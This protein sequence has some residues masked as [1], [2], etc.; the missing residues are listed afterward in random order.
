MNQTFFALRNLKKSLD[1]KVMLEDVNLSV[2]K[3]EFWSVVG[4]SG[5]GKSTLFE[6]IGGICFPDAGSIH[7]DGVDVTRMQPAKRPVNML[8][9]SYALFP[10]MSVWEN[11]AY[12]LKCEGKS[13][14]YIEGKVQ[15]MLNTLELWELVD[16]YPSQLSGG[17]KQ[18]VA[19]G[20]CL[21]KNPKLVLLD[22]PFSACD[23]NIRVKIQREIWDYHKMMNT[24]LLHIT[25]E[26]EDALGLSTH[27]AVMGGKTIQQ[28]GP[29]EEVYDHP[30]N[31]HIARSL[32]AMNIF[33]AYTTGVEDGEYMEAL[34]AVTKVKVRFPKP[35]FSCQ[36][37]FCFGVRP[38]QFCVHTLPVERAYNVFSGSV[39]TVFFQGDGVKYD[40]LIA[41]GMPMVSVFALRRAGGLSLS[42]GQPV[43]LTWS[44]DAT[45]PF[46]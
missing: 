15:N 5:V 4:P 36:E 10:H 14:R 28:S 32:G 43:W 42:R 8:F 38:E 22:E 1:K 40:V 12:G 13:R 26:P 45:V 27:I 17:Q 2:N 29:V 37:S 23:K 21:V 44:E 7:I 6:M 34:T 25:H 16:R 41:K 11:I 30:K 18:R 3:G 31:V 20:R 39:Q 35:K 19:M 46:A 9:Q 24:T 33:S